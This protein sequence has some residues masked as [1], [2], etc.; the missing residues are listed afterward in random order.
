M[1]DDKQLPPTSFFDKML[2]D[3]GSSLEDDD[4]FS[5]G[6][7]ESILGL[8]QAQGMPQRML[9]WHYRSR[10][11][12]LIAVSNKE[13]YGSRLNVAPS[14][15]VNSDSLGLRFRHVPS[16]IF[17]RGGSRANR[18]EAAEVARAVMEHARRFPDQSLGVG[19]FS[20][21]QRD[22]ILDE[23]EQLSA[24]IHRSNRTSCKA[25][26]IHSSSRIWRIFKAMNETSFL[27]PSDMHATRM[28]IWP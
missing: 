16:G 15:E 21:S 10:H 22:V 28:A 20:V 9:R 27:Y 18:I 24:M 1:G 6:D 13:F 26:R 8:C 19:A 4:T 5:A 11:D 14:A 2:A 17:D 23:V 12:S 7:I 25:N 3:D